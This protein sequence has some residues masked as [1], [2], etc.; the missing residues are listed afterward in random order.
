MDRVGVDGQPRTAEQPTAARATALARVAAPTPAG[1]LSAS[2]ALALQRA[3]GNRAV[4]R[5]ASL[6]RAA[7]PRRV[8]QRA[9]ADTTAPPELDEN[10]LPAHTP[11]GEPVPED[12]LPVD[13]DSGGALQR[14][15]A[16]MV[17]RRGTTT[18]RGRVLARYSATAA[19]A[20]AKKWAKDT[21]ADY[22]R[23]TNDCTNFVSQS[24]L[25]GGWAM[26]GDGCWHRKDDDVWWYGD[27]KCSLPTVR[28]S[29]TWSGAQNLFNFMTASG[30]A[31]SLGKISDL[32]VG[33]VLQMA[34]QA[35]DS[36]EPYNVGRV[37]HSMVVTDK[38]DGNVFLSYHTDD[39]LDEPFWG[40]GGILSRHPTAKYYAWHIK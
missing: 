16:R 30:R 2:E 10:K 36:T 28:A 9:E 4:A 25:A 33:D 24:L 12:A 34:F 13:Q 37:G 32:E 27:S 31:T 3:A 14:S 22:P 19:V 20:Y 5:L 1:R 15:A 39:H 11:S 7:L 26:T 17:S 6:S 18:V 8:V 21:N 40:A 38:H 35:D 23:F 29:F